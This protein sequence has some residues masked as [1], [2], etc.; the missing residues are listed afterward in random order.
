MQTQ[1]SST[2]PLSNLV[3]QCQELFSEGCVEVSLDGGKTFLAITSPLLGIAILNAD[4]PTI[5]RVLNVPQ[6]VA[7]R[8]AELKGKVVPPT[9]TLEPAPIEQLMAHL[10]EEA[11]A[12]GVRQTGLAQA[13]SVVHESEL[14]EGVDYLTAEEGRELTEWETISFAEFERLVVPF[15]NHA[16]GI[17]ELRSNLIKAEQATRNEQNKANTLRRAAQTMLDSRKK[18]E[19]DEQSL[20]T[21]LAS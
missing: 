17:I 4:E 7:G 11:V 5:R 20:A 1:S 9:T 2:S 10:G 12:T 14:E 21:L 8:V 19:Q 15:C 18:A 13:V 6:V 3:R 16:L